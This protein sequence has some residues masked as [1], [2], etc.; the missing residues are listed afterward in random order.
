MC[1]A[2]FS[3]KYFFVSL[4]ISSLTCGL[5]KSILFN[6]Q[7]FGDFPEN[8]LLVTS[9]LVPLVWENLLG[10]IWVFLIL[11]RLVLWPRM[12]ILLVNIQCL[13]FKIMCILLLL[14]GVYYNCQL[15]NTVD[16]V[17]QIFYIL[18]GFLSVFLKWAMP[19]IWLFECNC[20]LV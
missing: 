13:H 14:S 6:F 5:F 17:D 15:C 7:V 16:S 4:S 11:L 1:S 3:S 10:M 2:S 8:F 12:E 19:N 18:N 20:K 9:N